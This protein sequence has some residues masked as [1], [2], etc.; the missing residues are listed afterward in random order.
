VSSEVLSMSSV[1]KKRSGGILQFFRSLLAPK[2]KPTKTSPI[3]ARPR[4][5]RG[6]L[7]F[8]RSLLFAPQFVPRRTAATN[9]GP[10]R[11]K[12]RF[13]PG[14]DLLEDR[15]CPVASASVDSMGTL[16]IIGDPGNNGI[17]ITATGTNTFNVDL[18]GDAVTDLVVNCNNINIKSFQ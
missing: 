7:E 3:V 11:R 17:A 18:N 1:S 15:L 13:R 6:V 9:A 4:G 12:Q 10:V 14:L 16:T 2:K 8:F 5:F